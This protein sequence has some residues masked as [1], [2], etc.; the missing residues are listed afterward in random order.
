M[1]EIK[2][3]HETKSLH[4]TWE[5]RNLYRKRWLKNYWKMVESRLGL[6]VKK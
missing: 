2:G 1:K 6:K 4:E 3:L 5:S